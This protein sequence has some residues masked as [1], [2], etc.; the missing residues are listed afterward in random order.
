MGS[1]LRILY[2]MDP[3]AR[4]LVDKDTTFA[5][6]CEGERR[7]HEQYYCGIEVLSGYRSPPLAEWRAIRAQPGQ[8]PT[9]GHAATQPLTWFDAV[10]MRKDPPFDMAFFFSTHVLGLVDPRVTFVMNDPRGL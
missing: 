2:V 3:P 10:L 4:I 7:G 8:L 5:F 9:L 6:M 1:P